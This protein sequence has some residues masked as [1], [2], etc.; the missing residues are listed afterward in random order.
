MARIGL[1]IALRNKLCGVL[2]LSS[3][4]PSPLPPPHF[5]SPS[6]DLEEG[7][8]G[9]RVSFLSSHPPPSSPHGARNEGITAALGGRFFSPFF[10]FSAGSSWL[11]LLGICK[12]GSREDLIFPPPFFP[13]PSPLSSPPPPFFLEATRAFGLWLQRE[14]GSAQISFSPDANRGRGDSP[15]P[16]GPSPLP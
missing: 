3:L 15:S 5:Q 6:D 8:H 7:D 4:L 10:F 12:K 1:E 11:G 2:P 16:F 9:G 13:P 14:F